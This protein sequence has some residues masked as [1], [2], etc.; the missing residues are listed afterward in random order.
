MGLFENR[1]PMTSRILVVL[2]LA[3]GCG[4]RTS[5]LVEDR[6]EDAA[7]DAPRDIEFALDTAVE[8]TAIVVDVAPPA[9]P[10][11]R[12][13]PGESCDDEGRSCVFGNKCKAECVCERGSW[14]CAADTCAT[15]CPDRVP[16]TM[17]CPV[18]EVDRVCSY[19][20]GCPTT[21]RCDL[22]A[23]GARWNCLS[24]PC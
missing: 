14:V 8:D 2:A 4:A 23:D 11:R 19:P 17:R 9:C 22:V 6:V 13:L 12:P 3:C 15:S 7:V 24:P 18:S 5:P 1:A 21:C 20:R 16:A 10:T